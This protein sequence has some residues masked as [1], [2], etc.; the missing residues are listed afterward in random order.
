MTICHWTINDNSSYSVGISGWQAAMTDV[1]TGEAALQELQRYRHLL[2]NIPAEMA[3]FGAFN[4]RTAA[5]LSRSFAK[6][7]PD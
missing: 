4:S 7:A 5:A 3:E 6:A 2:D 1:P